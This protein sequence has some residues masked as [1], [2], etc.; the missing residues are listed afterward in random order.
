MDD[1]YGV[2]LPSLHIDSDSD[3]LGPGHPAASCSSN[4]I[5]KS[6]RLENPGLPFLFSHGDLAVDALGAAPFIVHLSSSDQGSELTS[7][8][9]TVVISR[10]RKGVPARST[11][12]KMKIASQWG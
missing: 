1:P 8:V 11:K 3:R 2:V 9:V 6:H 5:I 12:G 10:H 4:F 7:P